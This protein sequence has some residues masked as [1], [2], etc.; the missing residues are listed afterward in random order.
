MPKLLI[1]NCLS[2]FVFFVL[3]GSALGSGAILNSSLQLIM[4]GVQYGGHTY[5]L[6]LDYYEH[7]TDK[8]NLY[9]QYKSIDFSS[10]KPE[11]G[12]VVDENLNI[13]N[14]CVLVSGRGYRVNLN[15][16]QNQMNPNQLYWRL[17]GNIGLTPGEIISITGDDERCYDW[18]QIVSC[19]EQCAIYFSD[20]DA[21]E[22]YNECYD[23]CLPGGPFTIIITVYND[24]DSPLDF[25][26]PPGTVF[27]SKDSSV[28][29][30]IYL[31][32]VPL[33]PDPKVPSG[34]SISF[35]VDVFCLND[36]L[37]G[38]GAGDIY[39]INTEGI[40]S[41]CMTNIINAVAGKTLISERW[42]IQNI[43]WKCINEGQISHSDRNYLDSLTD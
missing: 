38:P 35:C 11:C 25:T 41:Q 34:A 30:M 16:Y 13:S 17:D 4:P 42:E 31:P 6:V 40:I 10:S 33:V 20:Y 7:P 43:V 15:Y 3:T 39:S 37:A 9:W 29:D 2:L 28:Q 21:Y 5:Y 14:V 19:M 18:E 36:D 1:V 23:S 8:S 24:G 26:L 12:G 27:P 32:L 22:D